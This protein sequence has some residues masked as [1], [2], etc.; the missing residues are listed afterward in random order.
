V[1]S[2]S[3]KIMTKRTQLIHNFPYTD[4]SCWILWNREM[5]SVAS[6]KNHIYQKEMAPVRAPFSSSL[7]TPQ[8]GF[9]LLTSTLDPYAPMFANSQLPKKKKKT[10]K[11]NTLNARRT[12]MRNGD[13]VKGFL[14]FS[15]DL[16]CLHNASQST[17]THFHPLTRVL[18]LLERKVSQRFSFYN[19]IAE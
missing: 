4:S 13:G 2:G 5:K 1:R 9:H 3:F 6:L 18:V 8:V 7:Q 11:R 10:R 14:G 15:Q 12:Q 19:L 17:A 16:S